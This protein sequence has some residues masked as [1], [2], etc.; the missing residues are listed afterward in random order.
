MEDVLLYLLG[1]LMYFSGVT[2][3]GVSLIQLG[4]RGITH[5]GIL[6]GLVFSVIAGFI[7]AVVGFIYAWE[8]LYR[9]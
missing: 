7:T 2:V 4:D 5:P 9:M 8:H 1:V 3:L 6:L